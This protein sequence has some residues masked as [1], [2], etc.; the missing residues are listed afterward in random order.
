MVAHVWWEEESLAA[1]LPVLP[2]DKK[3]YLPTHVVEVCT[4][5]VVAQRVRRRGAHNGTLPPPPS[6]YFLEGGGRRKKSPSCSL[7]L[8]SAIAL[9]LLLAVHG[10]TFRVPTTEVGD[11]FYHGIILSSFFLPYSRLCTGTS[12]DSF[13]GNTATWFG[14]SKISLSG[15]FWN[16]TA[17]TFF[18][19]PFGMLRFYLT[20][21][22]V[23]VHL[24]GKIFRKHFH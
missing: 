5:V 6:C 2:E 17:A 1:W 14:Y 20:V 9:L 21:C 11:F 4:V 7:V 10:F 18:A 13:A 12:E 15:R 3:V 24:Q 23:L 8:L 19:M 22:R 16:T